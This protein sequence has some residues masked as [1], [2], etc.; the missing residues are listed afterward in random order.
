MILVDTSVWV[1]HLRRKSAPLSKLLEAGRVLVHPF[2][3]GEVALGHMRQRNLILAA[4]SNLPR[5]QVATED[6]VLSFIERNAL[7]GRGVGYIDVH[8]LAAAQLTP[9][10]SLWTKDRKLHAVADALGLAVAEDRAS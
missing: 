4:L 3:I 6:E 8:L 1:D 7:F 9:G 5:T 2:V 10:A